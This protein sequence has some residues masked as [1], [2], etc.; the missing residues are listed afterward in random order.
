MTIKDVLGET[1]GHVGFI[2]KG[3]GY[4]KIIHNCDAYCG[5]IL[6][7]VAGRRCSIHYH[8]EKKETFYLN[9]GKMQIYYCDTLEPLQKL[10][11]ADTTDIHL[12]VY[13]YMETVIL[14]QGMKFEVPVGRVHQMIA[15]ED[16][17]LLEFSTPDTAEDSYRLIKGD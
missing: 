7:F 17:E 8:K 3:W 9:R 1:S 13:D 5:K 15:L 11:E 10:A 14:T 12:R 16:S 4:E 6:H 2:P